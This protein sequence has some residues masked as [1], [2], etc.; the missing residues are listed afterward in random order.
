M[1]V[2]FDSLIGT[3]PDSVEERFD[4]GYRAAWSVVAEGE[5]YLIKRDDRSEY[6]EREAAA[7]RHAAA[8]GIPTPALLAT[9]GEPVQFLAFRWVDGEPLGAGRLNPWRDAG[10]LM[11]RIHEMPT[12]SHAAPWGSL[13]QFEAELA[14]MVERDALTVGEAQGAFA[15]ARA[16]LAMLSDAEPVFIHGDCQ[17]DH[18]IVDAGGAVAAVIDWADAGTGYPE[19]DLA[20]MALSAEPPVFEA[21]LD[22]YR[23][24][25]ELRERL[26]RTLPAFQ[27]IRAA[28]SYR[29]LETHGYPGHTWPIERVRALSAG[30]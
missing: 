16:A 2:P 22:A 14:W 4:Y 8:N 21:L 13:E 15:A 7:N 30:P 27:A 3:G 9:R 28:L 10:A 5:R 18:F 20:V 6:A 25:P 12:G 17:P 23:P 29:W 24:S 11:R 26:P 19:M 1:G